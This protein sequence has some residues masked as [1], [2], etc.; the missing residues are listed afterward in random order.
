MSMSKVPP[1]PLRNNGR[2]LKIT[3]TPRRATR[4]EGHDQAGIDKA[5]LA[6][7]EAIDIPLAVRIA[8]SPSQPARLSGRISSRSSGSAVFKPAATKRQRT[9]L[10]LSPPTNMLSPPAYSL[11]LREIDIQVGGKVIE[12]GVINPGSRISLAATS[13]SQFRTQQT[14][15]SRSF[16]GPSHPQF[17]PGPDGF[18][19]PSRALNRASSRCL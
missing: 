18:Q 6:I 5:K 9:P 15:S 8:L 17:P 11:P 14:H 3:K 12:A 10:L 19:A 7:Q 2:L 16:G 4:F 1:P 13:R